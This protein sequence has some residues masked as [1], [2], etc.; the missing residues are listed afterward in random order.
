MSLQLFYVG[1]T[2]M[3]AFQ[4][5]LMNITN[6]VSNAQTTGFKKSRVEL[7]NLFPYMLEDA[8]IKLDDKNQEK[9]VIE[10]GSGVRVSSVNKDFTMGSIEMTGKPMDLAIEGEGFFQ[11]KM[12]DGSISYTR[13]GNLHK[14]SEGNIVDANGHLFEPAIK[15]PIYATS[16]SIDSEGRVYVKEK[17]DSEAVEIGQILLARFTN[18]SG[19]KSIGQNLYVATSASG[20]PVL[21]VPGKEST[22]SIAQGALEYSSVDIIS[23]MM[24]M[25]I[26]QRSF[27][28]VT[29][30]VQSGETMLKNATEIAR[31]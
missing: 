16:I 7:E 10:I 21:N 5:D 1:A 28:S 30:L 9:P 22:G 12:V 13:A 24:R 8:I 3:D 31:T 29:K 6:N 11:F 20:E 26:T 25:V 4:K 18:P 19:L 2:G 27:E 17:D 23:E 14:D 15:V